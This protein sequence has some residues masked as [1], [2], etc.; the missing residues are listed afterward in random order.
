MAAFD[1]SPA[2]AFN[3]LGNKL[4]IRRRSFQGRQSLEANFQNQTLTS[5]RHA[6][7]RLVWRP[8]MR[9]AAG[10][11]SVSVGRGRDP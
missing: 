10:N 6:V 2:R 8:L 5:Q 4:T 11:V 9:I 3:H 7:P 1:P